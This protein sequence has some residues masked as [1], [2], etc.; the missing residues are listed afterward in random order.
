V[1]DDAVH[2]VLV[3]RK[4][5]SLG[6][7]P[8][9]RTALGIRAEVTDPVRGLSG[10]GIE[11]SS[12]RAHLVGRLSAAAAKVAIAEPA[13]RPT[14]KAQRRGD[15]PEHHD[16]GDHEQDGYA[17]EALVRFM[18]NPQLEFNGGVEF[19]NLDSSNTSGKIG[20]V[21]TFT[22]NLAATAALGFSG[23]GTTFFIGG[24]LYFDPLVLRR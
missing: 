19:I 5:E 15:R 2:V 21:Y 3:E 10:R 14:E 4:I 18:I 6:D 22:H 16:R 24:R 12:E 7:D 9:L 8:Q 17:L 23:D 1:L 13:H 20:A 11:R